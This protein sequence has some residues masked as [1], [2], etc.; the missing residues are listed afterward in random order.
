MNA[1]MEED[2]DDADKPADS[3]PPL[4]LSANDNDD[5]PLCREEI[6][7]LNSNTG[8][9]KEEILIL[10]TDELPELNTVTIYPPSPSP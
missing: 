3:T 8:E 5:I 4:N 2:T 1:R 9:F 7:I 6:D 10:E